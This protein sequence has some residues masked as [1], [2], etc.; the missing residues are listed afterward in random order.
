M[1]ALY[2][3]FSFCREQPSNELLDRNKRTRLLIKLGILGEKS[4]IYSPGLV[5]LT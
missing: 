5:R 4:S 3:V 1:Y 2:S